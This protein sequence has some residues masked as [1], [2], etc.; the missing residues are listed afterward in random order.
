MFV[1]LYV[2]AISCVLT[3]QLMAN[4]AW[5]EPVLKSCKSHGGKSNDG[6]NQLPD[7]VLLSI[8]SCLTMKEAARTSVLCHKWRELW[9]FFP[10]TFNFEDP[11]TRLERFSISDRAFFDQD[12]YNFVTWVTHV[13]NQHRGLAVEE[14]KVSFGLSNTYQSHID[15]W[16]VFAL[17]KGAKSLVLDFEP[18]SISSTMYALPLKCCDLLKCPYNLPSWKPALKTLFLK[19]IRV[20]TGILDCFLHSCPF[21]ENLQIDG[22]TCLTSIRASGSPL[23]LKRLDLYD[24]PDLQR[25]E[26]MAPELVTFRY[27]GQ[28]IQLDI[29]NAPLLSK[30]SIGGGGEDP[31]AYAF[32]SLSDYFSQLK[33]LNVVTRIYLKGPA[34]DADLPMNMVVPRVSSF[35]NL[36]HLKLTIYARPYQTLLGWITLI[37]ACPVLQKLTLELSTRNI[38]PLELDGTLEE[39]CNAGSLG[40]LKTLEF[41]GFVGRRIDLEFATHVIRKAV[42]LELVVIDFKIAHYSRIFN[43]DLDASKARALGLGEILP[44][45]AK[46]VLKE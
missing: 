16:V 8:M 14:F 17:T 4:D 21:L 24:C 43:P 46:L 1:F 25:I 2:H 37:E 3:A 13:V 26:I 28:R 35:M 42:A 23:A 12:T 32:D 15:K 39:R 9:P 44:P 34:I 11:K 10:G 29:R 22:S 38:F 5:D 30:V 20:T 33:Y 40:C 31:I 36:K 7:E 19:H 6:L 27:E 41:C 18:A 45:G